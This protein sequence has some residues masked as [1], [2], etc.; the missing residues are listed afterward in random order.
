MLDIRGF[1]V[2]PAEFKGLDMAAE[3]LRRNQ[4]RNQELKQRQEGEKAATAKY[5][6]NYL[7]SKDAL[8]GTAYDPE[9]V[10]GFDA[11]LSQGY[12]LANKGA[13][14]N[15][16]MMAISPGVAKL[17]QYS[18]KAKLINQQIKSSIDKIKP[19]KGYNTE[20]LEQEAKKLAFYDDNG[21]LRDINSVDPNMDYVSETARLHPERITSG[22]GLDE[23]VAKSPMATDSKDVQTMY[24][25]KK[26]TVRYD[27]SHPFW[28]DIQMDDK[29]NAVT[30]KSGNPVGLD[31][32]S[33]PIVGDDGKP[34]V[35]PQTGQA[36]RAIAKPEF[37]AIMKH[38]PDIADYV[39]GQVNESFRAA[40]ADKVPTEGTPQWEMKARHILYD[41][42][43][44]RS[45]SSFKTLDK[46]VNTAPVT[47]IQLGFD[48]YGKGG[49]KGG[50]S[51]SSDVNINDIA[52]EVNAHV[53]KVTEGHGAPLNELSGTAQNTIL[54]YA[55]ELSGD[56]KLSQADIYLK[57]EKN[58]DISIK[59]TDGNVIGFMTANDLNLPSQPGIKEKR[60]VLKKESAT[61]KKEDLRSKYGY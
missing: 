19:Y 9:I 47:R 36:Y 28:E 60:E 26:R 42:L 24:A 3:Q 27:A 35:N 13:N 40:G 11:L 15:E 38:N 31:V 16:I 54:K 46:Q 55:R 45:K 33:Q 50:S 23:F 44:S 25:G 14:M 39:R 34:F 52:A 6:G 8:T 1:E 53:S 59:S 20:A 56:S 30:D 48:P 10:K 49:S 57:K 32:N 22:A 29:G 61:P 2:Q 12:E 17:N 41:E 43:K 18:T 58:G 7:D 21:Q 5:L 51:A 37:T 4:F